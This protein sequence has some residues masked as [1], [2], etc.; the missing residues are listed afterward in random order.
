MALFSPAALFE[1]ACGLS[2]DEYMQRNI[3]GPAGM[4]STGAWPESEDV[5]GRTAGY[6]RRDGAWVLN[7]E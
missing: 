3:F 7:A 2:Y 5:P 1:R 4:K 6:R